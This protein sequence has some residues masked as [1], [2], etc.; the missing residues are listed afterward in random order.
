MFMINYI[1]PEKAEGAIKE[2]YGM[3]PKEVGVPQPLQLY[4]ASPAYLKR[5]MTIIKYFTQN[6]SFDFP[7]LAALRYV[8]ASTTCFDQC[9]LFNKKL[10][11]SLGLTEN[12]ITT[13]GIVPSETFEDKDAALITLAAKAVNNPDSVTKEDLDA[14]SAHGWSDQEVFEGVAYAAQMSTV[15]IVFR[16]FANK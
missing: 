13:L 6:S 12:E 16:T 4:S 3:F 9:S 11:L 10:L 14:A 1:T 15:G 2:I 5:Q 8:G 7:L